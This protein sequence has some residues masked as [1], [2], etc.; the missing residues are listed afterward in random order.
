[1]TVFDNFFA[2]NVLLRLPVKQFG[3]HCGL[4]VKTRRDV[5]MLNLK[6]QGQSSASGQGHVRSRGDKDTSCCI[7][8]HVSQQV[9][10]IR[11]SPLIYLYSIKR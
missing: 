9:K 7:S 11:P 8:L 10:H 3:R 1:M 5:C 2:K 6:S 4:L